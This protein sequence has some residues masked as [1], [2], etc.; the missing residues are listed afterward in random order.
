MKQQGGGNDPTCGCD[1]QAGWPSASQFPRGGLQGGGFDFNEFN[2]ALTKNGKTRHLKGK[3]NTEM[4]EKMNMNENMNENM[5]MNMNENMRN[6]SVKKTSNK[7]RN[8]TNKKRGSSA[9]NGYSNLAYKGEKYLKNNNSGE[10]FEINENGAR[11]NSIG[12]YVTPKSGKPYMTQMPPP[13]ETE[14]QINRLSQPITP[15][16]KSQST[17]YNRTTQLP[18]EVETFNMAENYETEPPEG[19]TESRRSSLAL[20]GGARMSRK[21]Y[22]KRR[23]TRRRRT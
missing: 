8:K 4:N 15:V 6:K 5:N 19:Q 17:N 1:M 14:Q 13:L 9:P 23:S 7:K 16:T 3:W 10:V 20:N 2:L 18:P 12:F 21:K 11:G 22:H